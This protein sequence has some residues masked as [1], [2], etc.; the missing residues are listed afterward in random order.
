M[1]RSLLVINHPLLF[2]RFTAGD[3]GLGF[4][5]PAQRFFTLFSLVHVWVSFFKPTATILSMA[6]FACT[7]IHPYICTS[8]HPYFSTAVLLYPLHL[9]PLSVYYDSNVN[10]SLL[11]LDSKLSFSTL[12]IVLV[13]VVTFGGLLPYGLLRS[14][15]G[16]GDCCS[17]PPIGGWRDRSLWGWRT[18]NGSQP[19]SG[20][21]FTVGITYT[22]HC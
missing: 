21:C 2:K 8:V 22:T 3:G 10:S 14:S 12:Y 16:G 6:T 20:C 19:H 13:G 7:S 11:H 4:Y 5:S 9:S 18:G 1:L 17:R 15:G